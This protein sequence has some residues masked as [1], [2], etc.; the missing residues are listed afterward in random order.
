MAVVRAMQ[1]SEKVVIN[2]ADIGEKLS[3]L[4]NSLSNQQFKSARG[5]MRSILTAFPGV[6]SLNIKF[7]NALTSM[8]EAVATGEMS[9]REMST[10]LRSEF[11]GYRLRVLKMVEEANSPTQ[12]EELSTPDL[13]GQGLSG[14]KGYESS[15]DQL[16]KDILN[17][18]LVVAY[19]PV[20]PIS[21]PPLD[22][23]KLNANGFKS[24]S[25]AGYP[26]LHKQFIIGMSTEQILT[27]VTHLFGGDGKSSTAEQ[28]EK[29]IENFIQS[30]TGRFPSQKFMP[31]GGTHHFYDSTWVWLLPQ[32]HFNL[33][34]K[35][36]ASPVSVQSLH[37][38]RWSF[39]FAGK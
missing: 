20:I 36:T 28:R 15:R 5:I 2:E 26:V 6:K 24:D 32:S 39:P 33:F 17:R 25:F 4:E 29:V 12:K 21:S 37:I 31:V 11:N 14:L 1:K 22:I 27:E 10:E 13:I 8:E 19:A 3:D 23:A 34:K 7:L 38:K 9:L 30:V 16:E 18:G 35:C